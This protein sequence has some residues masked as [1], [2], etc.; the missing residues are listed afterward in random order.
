[1]AAKR[2][3]RGRK[4]RKPRVL[5]CVY[6]TCCGIYQVGSTVS[7]RHAM[8]LIR[9]WDEHEWEIV[10]FIKAPRKASKAGRKP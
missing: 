10:K 4:S 3:P 9:S 5:W 1:M 8:E 6:D 7:E 2:S